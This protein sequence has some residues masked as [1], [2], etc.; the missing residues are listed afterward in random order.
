MIDYESAVAL[1]QKKLEDMPG[2]P[3]GD[4]LVLLLEHTIERPFGWV[5]FYSSRLYRET[6]NIMFALG[7]NSP[8]IINRNSGEI[9]LT[10]TAHPVEKYIA[11]YETRLEH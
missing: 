10:G 5:F 7:G 1:A 2:L 6:G 11:E 8:F 9:V 4:T 3:N